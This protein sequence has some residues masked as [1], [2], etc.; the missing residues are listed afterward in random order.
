MTPGSS[1]LILPG[2][3]CSVATKLVLEGTPVGVVFEMAEIGSER[4]IEDVCANA[5]RVLVPMI[6]ERECAQAMGLV[7]GQ[8]VSVSGTASI[9]GITAR[10]LTP[11]DR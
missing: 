7:A 11:G 9:R 5:I 2:I 8:R 10:S 4:S 6:R 1:T 3:V